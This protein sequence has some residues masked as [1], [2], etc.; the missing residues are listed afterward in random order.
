M[1]Y[2]EFESNMGKGTTYLYDLGSRPRGF[3]MKWN[4]RESSGTSQGTGSKYG[5]GETV[6]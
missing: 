6:L 5:T 2:L 1:F 3:S 4:D